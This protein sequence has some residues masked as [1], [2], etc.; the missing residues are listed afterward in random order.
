M[1]RFFAASCYA[2]ARCGDDSAAA[3]D[4]AVAVVGD[5]CGWGSARDD[6]LELAGGGAAAV[7]NRLRLP[8]EAG[9]HGVLQRVLPGDDRGHVPLEGLR[10]TRLERAERGG[11]DVGGITAARPVV[12]DE[13][14]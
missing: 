1:P 14:R 9:G 7:E 8:V 10:L 4:D 13:L 12:D 2:T 6:A 11:A 5:L 3:G